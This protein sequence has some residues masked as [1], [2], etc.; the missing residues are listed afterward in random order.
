MFNFSYRQVNQK[1]VDAGKSMWRT[2]KFP[3]VWRPC[4]YMYLSIAL[5]IDIHEGL[6]YWYTDSKGGPSFSEETVGFIFLDWC[7][8]VSLWSITLS[9][10]S[11]GSPI[12]RRT[13]LGSIAIWFVWNAR[14]DS[15]ATFELETRHCQII[16]SLSLT[17][18]SLR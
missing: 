8:R 15:G 6:F 16:S 2:L 7:D 18:V 12:S 10:C 14:F 5:S 9:K 17:R 1:L 11:E 3:D 4:V 13:F